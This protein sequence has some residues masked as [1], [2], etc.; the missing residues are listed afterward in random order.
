V[1]EGFTKADL[2]EPGIRQSSMALLSLAAL[3]VVFGDIGTSP[4]YALRECFFGP[5]R[6][7]A[8]AANVLGVLS[9]VFWSL[10]LVVS[11][12]YLVFILRA[13][14]RGEGGILSL[15]ALVHP[16]HAAVRRPEGRR[17]V[18]ARVGLILVALFG[19]ALL[20]GDGV[21]TPAISVLSAVEGLELATPAFGPF[22]IPLAV[23]ILVGFFLVQRHGTGRVGKV[24]G[25][26]TLVWFAVLGALGV[27]GLLM[28]PEV[29]WA[30]NPL[31]GVR[32]FLENGFHG[33]L[34]LGSVFLVVTGGEAL[35]ADMGH[36]GRMPIRISWFAIVLPALMLNYFG[37]GALLLA[38]GEGSVGAVSHPFF[39]LAPAW[40]LIPLVVLATIATIIASQAMISGAFALTA[41]AIHL[42]YCPRLRI[43]HTS[44]TER[45]Q[46]YV[47]EVNWALMVMTIWLV[48]EFQSSSG[49][50]A[51][52][53]MAMA[54]MMVI[55]TALFAVVVREL[56]G[57]KPRTIALVIGPLFLIDLAFFGAN[58]LKILQGGWVPIVIAVVVFT[59]MS[60]WR[61][62]RKVLA[63][64]LRK[65]KLPIN[66][67]LD[68]VRARPPTR[69]TGTA[70]FMTGSPDAT[71]PALIHN[72]RHNKVLHEQ[73]V[74]LTVFTE[75]VPRLNHY[76]RVEVETL[77]D[78]FYRII[79]RYGFMEDPSV[80]EAM[81]L[82][83][84]RGFRF[85]PDDVT[86]FL[87]RE[88]IIATKAKEPG[89]MALWRERL[90]AA[91]SRNAQ[92]ATA[93][94]RIPPERVVEVGAQVKM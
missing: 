2:G 27:R 37:Q 23:G 25:P 71:P 68:L 9:L 92:Q 67:F 57:W 46:V 54:S 31:H 40:A 66:D 78:G 28:A 11:V 60:T 83:K 62:G 51:A 88:R 5:H 90:F 86:Y 61:K 21:I 73:V 7:D 8:S 13:D 14:N 49:L 84:G 4:L 79:A 85:D 19:A 52:Y 10:I 39:Q 15:L 20:Y 89:D 77:G 1:G 75:E 76:E 91:M 82:A 35:Y 64:R 22:V 47:P 26:I 29:L 80:P 3:G 59:M 36:F 42:G 55:T 43:E 6:V 38:S 34:I 81:A 24:F 41:Q 72:V 53:G 17:A 32:F 50:A 70:V 30:V 33:F 69:V 45:G 74:F 44:A 16:E 93:F 58:A 18:G 12:K 94:F 65:H 48:L 87:G 56:W 63:E